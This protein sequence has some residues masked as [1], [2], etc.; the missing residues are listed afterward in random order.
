M[1]SVKLVLTKDDTMVM[2]SERRDWYC[3]VDQEGIIVDEKLYDN[4]S[5]ALSEI[6]RLEK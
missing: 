5:A 2:E 4:V 3:I 1:Y 6:K